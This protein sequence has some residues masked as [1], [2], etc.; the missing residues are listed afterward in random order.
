VRKRN[1]AGGGRG[2]DGGRVRC[3]GSGENFVDVG[4]GE[5]SIWLREGRDGRRGAGV[6]RQPASCDDA[7]M[8]VTGR[9]LLLLLLQAS[10][11]SSRRDSAPRSA[12]QRV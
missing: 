10:R 3:C 12:A 8:P 7:G 4:G 2:A 11:T 6:A 5:K 9:M 1:G